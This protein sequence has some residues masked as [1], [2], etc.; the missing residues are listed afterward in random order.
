[1]NPF[2]TLFG[3]IRQPLLF[4]TLAL[5]ACGGGSVAT[6]V[7]EEL[8]A[9]CDQDAFTV[10]TDSELMPGSTEIEAQYDDTCGPGED[11]TLRAALL[12]A[13]ICR[14]HLDS[15]CAKGHRAPGRCDV[16]A[17]GALCSLAR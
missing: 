5:A 2:R 9:L 6:V 16:H 7:L 10:N 11:C 3:S 1:M 17:L 15:P 4:A 12:S 8:A 13:Y 14:D